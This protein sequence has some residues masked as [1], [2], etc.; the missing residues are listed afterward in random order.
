MGL[1]WM[2]LGFKHPDQNA[3]SRIRCGKVQENRAYQLSKVS[4]KTST[5]KKSNIEEK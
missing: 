4:S 1:G 5:I 2:Q 3:R